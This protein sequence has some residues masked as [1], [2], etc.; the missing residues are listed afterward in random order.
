MRC[1]QSA[2]RRFVFH[3]IPPFLLKMEMAEEKVPSEPTCT[4]LISQEYFLQCFTVL[5]AV[6]TMMIRCYYHQGKEENNRRANDTAWGTAPVEQ[7]KNYVYTSIIPKSKWLF[8][9][10]KGEESRISFLFNCYGRQG[11]AKI[12]LLITSPPYYQVVNEG[13]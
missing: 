10:R 1:L 3:F 4:A 12:L 5:F 11:H 8:I 2:R 6:F 9:T 13:V 7:P